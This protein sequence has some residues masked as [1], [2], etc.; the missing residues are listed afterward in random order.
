[1]GV[2]ANIAKNL[3][4]KQLKNFCSSSPQVTQVCRNE[5]FYI[6]L[7]RDRFPKYH[8]DIS[9]LHN[10]SPQFFRWKEVYLGLVY[11]EDKINF[12]NL[13]DTNSDD[14][15]SHHLYFTSI[16]QYLI[17][18]YLESLR[19]LILEDFIQFNQDQVR[20]ITNQV[21]NLEIIKHLLTVYKIEDNGED[22]MDAFLNSIGYPEM[23]IFF[24][25]YRGVGE[26]GEEVK[27]EP[28]DINIS[29]RYNL[30]YARNPEIDPESYKI[31]HNFVGSDYNI[32]DLD[33]LLE[34]GALNPRSPE[35]LQYFKEILPEVNFSDPTEEEIEEIEDIRSWLLRDFL[36]VNS[37][38]YKVAWDR[39]KHL[40]TSE[41]IIHIRN[42]IININPARSG[43]KQHRENSEELLSFVNV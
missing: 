3:N 25:N 5:H 28:D 20:N 9:L 24:L 33:L 7:I 26:F 17:D 12:D 40:L 15:A 32:S 30:I 11:I 29:T 19:Y 4:E 43:R 27:I 38:A 42:K 37:R 10:Q 14:N 18:N 1:V 22:L 39:Y 31:W 13:F 34:L 16:Q 2:Y 36:V 8:R 23:M 6:Q 41:E 35:M 21:H